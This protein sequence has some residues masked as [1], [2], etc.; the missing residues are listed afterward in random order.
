MHCLDGLSVAKRAWKWNAQWFVNNAPDILL[1]DSSAACRRQGDDLVAGILLLIERLLH[2][3][4]KVT[5]CRSGRWR[6]GILKTAGWPLASLA[7]LPEVMAG[8]LRGVVE[9]VAG[10]AVASFF[11]WL[12][13]GDR[14]F[15]NQTA[16]CQT[17]VRIL[18]Q[19]SRLSAKCCAAPHE[20]RDI[21]VSFSSRCAPLP[22]RL[23]L[24]MFLIS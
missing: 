9:E 21:T 7:K 13:S 8:V 10:E 3:R 16:M 24:T 1:E 17:G 12:A 2:L 19:P 11:E 23:F 18:L 6:N 5:M 20:H 22:R 14:T 15:A 4:S